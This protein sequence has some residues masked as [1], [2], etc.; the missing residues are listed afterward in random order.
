MDNN[1]LMEEYYKENNGVVKPVILKR[2]ESVEV[3]KEMSVEEIV[4]FVKEKAE[5]I[6]EDLGMGHIE[7]VYENALEVELKL[8]GLEFSKQVAIPINYKGYFIG[9][10]IA[11]IV[12]N[13]KLVIELKA[14]VY[15]I[16]NKERRQVLKYMKPLEIDK[17]MVINFSQSSK[18]D[19]QVL[20]EEL[21]DDVTEM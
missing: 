2:V 15:N 11:D 21:E 18:E 9:F 12:I 10:G 4:E 13:D 20:E 7:L 5:E 14:Q 6:Y 8:R 1:E 3:K 17:G 19:L 16:G